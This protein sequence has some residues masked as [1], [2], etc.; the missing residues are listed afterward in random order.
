MSRTFTTQY[1]FPAIPTP[2]VDGGG[3]I[4]QP[5]LHLLTSLWNRTGGA[6]GTGGNY[7][8]VTVGT[9]PFTYVAPRN[10][11][12]YFGGG[13]YVQVDITRGGTTLTSTIVR[14]YLPLTMNDSAVLRFST[15]PTVYFVG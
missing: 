9:S 2:F 13:V 8:T 3:V 14:G 11:F 4:T 5:W 12:L 15:P 10:G 7:L 6:G 1:G